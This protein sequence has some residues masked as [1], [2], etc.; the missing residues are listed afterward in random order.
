VYDKDG[1]TIGGSDCAWIDEIYFPATNPTYPI[2]YLAPTMIDFG[3]VFIGTDSTVC[4][5]IENV[6]G[7]TLSGTITTPDCFTVM[8]SGGTTPVTVLDY[9]LT[10]GE[11]QEYDLI[12]C[13]TFAQIYDEPVSVSVF[14]LQQEYINVYGEGIPQTGLDD[15]EIFSE[16]KLFGNFPNPVGNTTVISYQLKGSAQMQDV[17]I[18]IYNIH[19]DYVTTIKGKKGRALLDCSQL[20][21]GVYLYKLHHEDAVQI[22]K[23]VILK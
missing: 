16:T 14:P 4:F 3:Q 2:L 1:N 18:D 17:S 6:G 5:E 15:P 20:G 10:G 8:E 13:P 19:G 21:N 12:F 7:G 22:Q 23:M 9:S 11:S